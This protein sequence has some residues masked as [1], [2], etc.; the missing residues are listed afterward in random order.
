[1]KRKLNLPHEFYKGWKDAL[2]GGEEIYYV[3]IRNGQPYVERVNPMYFDYEKSVD[4]EY[5]HDAAWCCRKMIMSATEIYDRFYDKM[6][7]K[8]LNELLELIDEKPGS[9]M[10]PQVGKSEL[11]YNHVKL[12]KLN[13]FTDNPFDTDQI[14]VYHCC[15][16]S[17]KKIGFVTLINEETGEIEEY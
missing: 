14:T 3:G 1:L 7:E 5:I 11:D 15:W 13:S 4:L 6:S 2:I 9:G 12:H 8:Q 16:K 10:T 17:F